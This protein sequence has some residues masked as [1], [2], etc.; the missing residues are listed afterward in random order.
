DE[1]LYY[2]DGDFMSRTGIDKG[3]ITLHP[4]G[5]PHGPHPGTYEGS[6]GKKETY[7]LAVMIDTFRP[8]K[9]TKN[10]L[11]IDTGDYHLSWL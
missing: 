8:L 9:L 2:V 7:E 1:V 4:S 6:I 10:A 3:Y 11:K 5:I